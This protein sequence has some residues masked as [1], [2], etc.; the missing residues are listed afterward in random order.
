MKPNKLFVIN[1]PKGISSNFY[2]KKVKKKYGVKK[3]GFSGTLD[4][5]ADGC[6][7][8]AFGQYNKLFR[9]LKKTPKKYKATLWIGAKSESLDNENISEVL[10]L[11]PFA[12]NSIEIVF[13]HLKGEITYTPPKFSAKKIAGVRAYKM[14]RE[15]KEFELPSITSTIHEIKIEHYK[16]PF[17]TFSITVSEGTYIRSIG[18]IIAKKLGFNGVLS[19]LSRIN[20]G[21]FNF[22]NEKNLNPIPF[23][24]TDKNL[25]LQDKTDMIL[26]KKLLVENFKIQNDGIYHTIN[27]NYLAIIKIENKKVSYMLNNIILNTENF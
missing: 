22:D 9:F 23:L 3:A 12:I 8:T 11:K 14:A 18:E 17:L 7:I 13:K 10:Y 2:L 5:F 27:D 26:G 6:L 25:Y 20:E 24:N 21:K 1:K 15:E 16:H 19:A 4:P